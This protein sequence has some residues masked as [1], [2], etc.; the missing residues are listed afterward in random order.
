ML[1]SAIARSYGLDRALPGVYDANYE[2]SNVDDPY[3]NMRRPGGFSWN[4]FF[5][6]AAG[7]IGNA[8]G[9]YDR[10]QQAADLLRARPGTSRA[11]SQGSGTRRVS[12]GAYMP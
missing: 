12:G 2:R 7:A 8:A 1:A 11:G 6:D 10:N 3:A 9:Q 4:G 5:A